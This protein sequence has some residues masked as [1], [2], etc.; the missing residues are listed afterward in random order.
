MLKE[1][2]DETFPEETVTKPL[3][4]VFFLSNSRTGSPLVQKGLINMYEYFK[5]YF[6]YYITT[7]IHY[8]TKFIYTKK[9]KSTGKMSGTG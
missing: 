1:K 4:S 7:T 2:A 9:R 6:Q 3:T 8:F 5:C